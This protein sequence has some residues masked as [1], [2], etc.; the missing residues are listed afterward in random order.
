MVSA[1]SASELAVE[2]SLLLLFPDLFS[3]DGQ[4][5]DFLSP[6]SRNDKCNPISE[7]MTWV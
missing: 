2:H 4:K 7:K 1:N 3:E 5:V 6:F